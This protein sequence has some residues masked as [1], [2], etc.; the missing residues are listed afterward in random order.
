MGEGQESDPVTSAAQNILRRLRLKPGDEANDLAGP[1]VETCDHGRTLG[2]NRLH[3][4]SETE[5]EHGHASP[6]AL[7]IPGRERKRANPES[8]SNSC[9]RIWIPGPALRAVPE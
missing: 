5:V 2:R 4:R 1:N 6:P 9:I 8:R 7:V 3:L